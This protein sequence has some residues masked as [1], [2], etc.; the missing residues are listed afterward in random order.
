MFN[1]SSCC[2]QREVWL[3]SGDTKG[4]WNISQFL[5]FEWHLIQIINQFSSNFVG[6]FS[7]GLIANRVFLRPKL[8][9]L[10]RNF[11]D[12]KHHCKASFQPVHMLLKNKSFACGI[13][14]HKM[15][16]INKMHEGKEADSLTSS[17]HQSV[18]CQTIQ[19]CVIK[20]SVML[21]SAHVKDI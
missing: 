2:F 5:R 8:A 9:L 3:S 12:V 16:N 11:R 4:G 10:C 19:I 6:N 1:F 17:E 18:C 14:L 21:Y 15:A 20:S 13:S 7:I